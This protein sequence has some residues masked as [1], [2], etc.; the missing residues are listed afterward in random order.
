M[1]GA[2]KQNGFSI[3][4]NLRG[5]SLNANLEGKKRLSESNPAKD[6]RSISIKRAPIVGLL[7]RLPTENVKMPKDGKVKAKI[8]KGQK[9]TFKSNQNLE[10]KENN[11]STNT[12][13]LNGKRSEVPVEPKKTNHNPTNHLTAYRDVNIDDLNDIKESERIAQQYFQGQSN[14]DNIHNEKYDETA[15]Q[16]IDNQQGNSKL[17]VSLQDNP[18]KDIQAENKSNLQASRVIGGNVG[19]PT[20]TTVR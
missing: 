11:A 19:D 3:Q 6:P 20:G 13:L 5:G 10:E 15:N 18:K 16:R 14:N 9:V 1:K 7:G 12:R 17:A 8:I 2:N 4:Q